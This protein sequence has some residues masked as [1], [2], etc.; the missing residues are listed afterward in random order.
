MG[1]FRTY[2]R[3]GRSLFKGSAKL[4]VDPGKEGAKIGELFNIV[5]G[6]THDVYVPQPAFVIRKPFIVR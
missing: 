1:G 4:G 5:E 2:A 3:G 6:K